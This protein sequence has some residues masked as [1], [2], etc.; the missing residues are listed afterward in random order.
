MLIPLSEL[1]TVDKEQEVHISFESDNDEEIDVETEDVQVDDEGEGEVDNNDQEDDDSNDGDDDD[2]DNNNLTTNNA[3]KAG[4]VAVHISP[5][6]DAERE[7]IR[8]QPKDRVLDGDIPDDIHNGTM[9]EAVPET[10]QGNVEK[11]RK[12]ESNN[13]GKPDTNRTDEVESSSSSTPS[14]KPTQK[15]SKINSLEQ[16]SIKALKTRTH[17][18]IIVEGQRSE[19]PD[20]E[21][22]HST[23]I[24][25]RL[26]PRCVQ[27]RSGSQYKLVGPINEEVTFQQGFPPEFV[28]A[29]KGGFPDDWVDLV[30]DYFNSQNSSGSEDE[31]QIEEQLE[32][33]N[34]KVPKGA[35]H[36]TFVTPT[37]SR[38]KKKNKT[39][40]F[41]TPENGQIPKEVE[42]KTTR[43]GRMVKPPLAWWRGQRILTDKN[44]NL[45]R[46]DPGGVEGTAL[47]SM[48]N[49]DIKLPGRVGNRLH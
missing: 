27:T 24:V 30:S 8:V 31:K 18:G 45:E 47:S 28:K 38:S 46:I 5:A 42:I 48:Y 35:K 20:G 25:E 4:K 37:E 22:W 32:K 41:N 17:M 15:T 33:K 39:E 23:A 26:S 3:K 19:D 21:L 36:S 6:L 14:D 49:V 29:F 1:K 40:A 2:D 12:R 34:R 7:R 10:P 43:S 44:H 16:W 9:D 11:S 13:Q